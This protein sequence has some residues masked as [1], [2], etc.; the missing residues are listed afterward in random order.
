MEHYIK[1][2][3]ERGRKRETE[4]GREGA[5]DGERAKE[6]GASARVSVTG[7]F[8]VSKSEASYLSEVT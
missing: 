5:R 3:A 2:L 6:K 1:R 4:G 8:S 7:G